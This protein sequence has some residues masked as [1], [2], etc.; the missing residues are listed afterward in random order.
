[1][2]LPDRDSFSDYYE[3]INEPI[4]LND[5]IQR[6]AKD[7]YQGNFHNFAQDLHTLIDN[8]KSYNEPNSIVYKDARHFEVLSLSLSLTITCCQTFFFLSFFL[9]ENLESIRAI[10]SSRTA[11]AQR[12]FHLSH[13]P[14]SKEKEGRGRTREDD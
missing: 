3:V 14:R 12:Q 4:S 1:M 8:A 13:D 9:P 10:G 2:D 5:I 7:E 11:K 6:I